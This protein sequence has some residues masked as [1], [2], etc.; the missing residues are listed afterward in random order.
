MSGKVH[1][2]GAG[3]SGLAAAVTLASRG[4]PVNVYEAAGFAGGRCRSYLDPHLN[5]I[6]DNGNHLI[7]S[8]NR[9][10]FAYLRT[11]GA[12]KKFIAPPHAEYAFADIARGTRWTI[13]A[14]D[15]AFPTWI[16]SRSHRVP[17]TRAFDYLK[18]LALSRGSDAPLGGGHP[19]GA[20]WER[21]MRP[22]LI[23]ALNTE[24]ETGSR[25]LIAEVMRETLFAGG[26]SYKPRIAKPTLAA[27][28]VDPA[29]MY[30]KKN[31]APIHFGQRLHGFRSVDNRVAALGFP[32]EVFVSPRDAVVLAV[33]PP[34]AA[35]LVQG[36][37]VP[38]DFRAIV[39]GHF[40]C[41][42]P[43]GTAPIMGVIGGTVEWIFA[44][45]D[46]I[47]VTVSNA[48]GIVD[49]DRTE[50]AEVFWRDVCA[51]LGLKDALPQWQIVKEK[52]A[53]FAAT[54]EQDRKRPHAK[55]A[56]SNLFLAGDWTQTGLPAT[57]EGAIRSGQ[58][59]AELA[60]LH[61]AM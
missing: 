26:K 11:I 13:K 42:P 29:L 21:L 18:L 7:L 38:D 32:H 33:P 49:R 23:A 27:A 31:G 50:L 9:A 56:Y 5:R 12:A 24:P 40:A 53:T 35:S 58:R 51:A 59:A 43:P 39:S 14:N 1:I 54:P 25:N 19:H 61:T 47:S 34:I 45:E 6:I 36:L 17:G 3:L 4:V 57:I 48:D 55:T 8:G 10:A 52:R 2:V 44:F 37:T 22:F 46:R 60:F 15:G 28:F 20:L 41:P 30:L 16:F